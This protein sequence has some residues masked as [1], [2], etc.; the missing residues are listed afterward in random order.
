MVMVSPAPFLFAVWLL[1]TPCML[2]C[3]CDWSVFQFVSRMG[4]ENTSVRLPGGMEGLERTGGTIA[5]RHLL[6]TS[7]M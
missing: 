1:K 3:P 5:A 4:D 7:T 2:V 6:L